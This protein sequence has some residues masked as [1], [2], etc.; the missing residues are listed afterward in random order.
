MPQKGGLN[1]AALHEREILVRASFPRSWARLIRRLN[2]SRILYSLLSC[3]WTKLTHTHTHTCVLVVHHDTISSCRSD[4]HV[5][6]LRTSATWEHVGQSDRNERVLVVLA[7]SAEGWKL[8]QMILQEAHT[9]ARTRDK[10]KYLR[11]ARSECQLVRVH[12]AECILW[13]SCRCIRVAS[14]FHLSI[15]RISH[16]VIVDIECREMSPRAREPFSEILPDAANFS[17]ENSR[18][19]F[20]DNLAFS[21]WNGALVWTLKGLVF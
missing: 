7:G 21:G 11:H 16:R 18:V 5:I 14:L 12:F 13:E 9:H 8:L 3:F 4:L 17:E 20:G 19:C 1:S 15:S 6:S 2:R 10:S